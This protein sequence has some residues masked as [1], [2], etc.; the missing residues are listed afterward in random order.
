MLGTAPNAVPSD[1]PP[2]RVLHVGAE[3]FPWLK[4]G[5]LADVMAAL[6]RALRDA[7]DDVRVLVPG[8]PAFVQALRDARTVAR[9]PS[10]LGAADVR[11]LCG[12]LEPGDVA[13]YVI[14]APDFY[15]RE[16]GPY[17]DAQQRP[18]PDNH[19]RFALLSWV[20][21][22]LALG[23]DSAWCA[24]VVHAHDWHAGLVPAYLRAARSDGQAREKTSEKAGEKTGEKADASEH[25][26]RS[27]F[28]V[29][30]LAYQGNFDAACFADVDLP[31]ELW[32][33]EGVEFHGQLSF[34]KAGLRLADKITTVS[35]TYAREIRQPS[36]GCG[37][38]GLL[39]ARAHDLV[40]ILNGVDDAVWDPATDASIEAR[41]GAED[42]SGKSQC[43]AA[44]QRSLGL[45][46]DPDRPLL[47][48]VS[49]LTEQKGLNLVQ[50][51]LPDLLTTGAQLVVLGS[52]DRAMEQAFADAAK[53]H[54]S[55]VAVRLGYDE[56]LAHRIVAGSDLIVVPSR[57]EPCGLTQ[58]Y[59]LRYGTLP[60]VRRV[61]GLAD[62][63]VDATLE[64]LVDGRATGFVFDTFDAVSLMHTV[65]QALALYRRPDDWLAMQWHAMT[66][67]FGWG[68][69][70][71]AYRQ[72]YREVGVAAVA[73]DAVGGGER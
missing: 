49:R 3:R 11:L 69:S 68:R 60:V 58:L 61:G 10:R 38:D 20:G 27:I 57:F 53:A 50:Q 32:G 13:T 48:I 66:R 22:Q 62:T 54:P 41:F 24:Q 63:V 9:W 1:L 28:T 51:A 37:F 64:H 30:N 42:L 73:A 29:H 70:A 25:G 15:A 39:R 7:G 12:H 71:L 26:A 36:Q 14:D 46:V 67:D 56:T 23:L 65:R 8:F 18:W 2:M 33:I 31:S 59:G 21:A 4:T 5:G 52:G 40:G 35:P 16:G 47:G 72:L 44:L 34:M 19:R 45:E 55:S 6:P 43:K 17:A